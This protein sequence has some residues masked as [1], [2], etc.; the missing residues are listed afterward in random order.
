MIRT[1]RPWLDCDREAALVA[2]L[3]AGFTAP[4][5]SQP[6]GLRR[7]LRPR[8]VRDTEFALFSSCSGMPLTD[9]AYRPL[10]YPIIT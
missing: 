9:W 2:M 8:R 4:A 1:R 3:S 10:R 5:Y 7:H 6:K